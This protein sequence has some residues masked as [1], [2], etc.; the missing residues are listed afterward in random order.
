MPSPQRGD[1]WIVD[2]GLAGKVR[3]GLV[4]SIP[5]ELTDRALVTIVPHTT[6][7]RGSQYEVEINLR[8]LSQHGAF[9]T[10]NPVTVS[11]AKLVRRAG[12]VTQTQMAVIEGGLYRWLG[13]AI[14][15]VS[16]GVGS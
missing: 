1:V 7:R 4:V 2:L 12:R 10:Q 6:S 15:G 14:P 3:P 11:N 13:L 9:D 16:G 8:F 5:A